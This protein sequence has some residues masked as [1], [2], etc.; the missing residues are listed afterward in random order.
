MF[1]FINFTVF[2]ADDS[3]INIGGNIDK[4]RKPDKPPEF[5]EETV[6]NEIVNDLLQCRRNPGRYLGLMLV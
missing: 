1:P 6:K 5:D 4:P 3:E 2:Q